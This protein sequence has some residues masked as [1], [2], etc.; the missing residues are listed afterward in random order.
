MPL[1][2]LV[3]PRCGRGRPL[4]LGNAHHVCCVFNCS[5]AGPQAYIVTYAHPGVVSITE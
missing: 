5:L 4:R 2:I 3:Q 1:E